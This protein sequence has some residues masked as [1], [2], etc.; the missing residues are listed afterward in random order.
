MQE[1]PINCG[2]KAANAP[3][4][5][6]FPDGKHN[7]YPLTIWIHLIPLCA[8]LGKELM[9]ST[10]IVKPP[11]AS[12]YLYIQKSCSVDHSS[13]ILLSKYALTFDPTLG[14]T[15]ASGI[16]NDSSR[17]AKPTSYSTYKHSLHRFTTIHNAIGDKQTPDRHTER[18]IGIDR[19]YNGSIGGLI[20]H[21]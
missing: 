18:P 2:T 20:A 3:E 11:M 4:T 5:K 15:W 19:L 21:S 17:N 6:T 16:E 14:I 8:P 9:V 1:K 12:P 13:V 10:P 7:L